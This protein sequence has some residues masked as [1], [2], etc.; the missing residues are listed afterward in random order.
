MNR[1]LNFISK[2]SIAKFVCRF[3]AWNDFL[4]KL[5]LDYDRR[6]SFTF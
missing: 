3:A 6:L 2:F 5:T 1:C 4:N